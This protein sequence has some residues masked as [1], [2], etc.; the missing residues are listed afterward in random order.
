M[1]L[2]KEDNQPITDFCK[3]FTLLI[4]QRLIKQPGWFHVQV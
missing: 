4:S 2:H 1:A 3:L